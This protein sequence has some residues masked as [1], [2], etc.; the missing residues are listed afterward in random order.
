MLNQIQCPMKKYLI[1]IFL[2][3]CI[4]G[5]TQ[6]VSTKVD[7]GSA[8]NKIRNVD[9][10]SSVIQ[11]EKI[12]VIPEISFVDA[13]TS[14]DSAIY[15]DKTIEIKE[16]IV[17]FDPEMVQKEFPE[18]VTLDYYKNPIIDYDSFIPIILRMLSE[19]QILIEELKTRIQILESTQKSTQ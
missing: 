16:R 4:Y 15:A 5:H 17:R 11:I 7:T 8:L 14:A 18:V 3:S 13:L 12:H 10:Q 9:S 2:C 19:Q 6:T 1:F